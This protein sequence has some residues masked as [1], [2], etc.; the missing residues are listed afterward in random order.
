MLA[1]IVP[2]AEKKKQGD[3]KIKIVFDLKCM[4]TGRLD[5]NQHTGLLWF[6]AEVKIMA[7]WM[8]A[9]ALS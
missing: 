5:T 9:L 3:H 6:L 2:A 8:Y 7:M 4:I 1:Y